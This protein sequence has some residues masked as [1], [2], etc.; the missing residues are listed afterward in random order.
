MSGEITITPGYTFTGE[1]DL[2]TTA[3]LN[4]LA[5]P[6]GRVTPGSITA[7]EIDAASVAGAL[8]NVAAAKNHFRDPLLIGPWKAT[9]GLSCAID[10]NIFNHADWWARPN[11]AGGPVV[12]VSRQTV[13]PT[14]TT[15]SRF[16][17]KVTGDAATTGQVSIGQSLP[18]AVT[19]T[20]RPD[21]VVSFWLYNGTG[22]D[23][24][25]SVALYGNSSIDDH[26]TAAVLDSQQ[27][28]ECGNGN[29][30]LVS[31]AFTT[32]ALTN[33]LNGG[34]VRVVIPSGFLD[35]GGKSV[36]I[37]Q[38]Q[39]ERASVAS[40]FIPP[41]HRRAPYIFSS[42]SNPAVTNDW[43]EGYRAGDVWINTTDNGVFVC[44]LADPT[45]AAVWVS[46][47]AV[48]PV[49]G[50]IHLQDRKTQNT[51]GGTATSGAFFTR[52]LNTELV[53]TGNHCTLSG[54]LITL[55]AGT[56]EILAT[57][58]G[59][60]VGSFQA[61]LINTTDGGMVQDINGNELYSDTACSAAA[62][63]VMVRATLMGRF[64][65]A[66]G[67]A[68][69]LSMRVQTNG[70]TTGNGIAANFG[71]EIYTQVWLTKLA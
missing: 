69:S 27:G 51:A 31:V 25:P 67:K 66:A 35:A 39:L 3:K 15:A 62:D 22:T 48:L 37:A 9:G 1:N 40:D 58:P 38:M 5:R 12:D 2:V 43:T 65:I 20:L 70:T 10:G 16:A 14:G 13:T 26:S 57:V 19:G 68:L 6:V 45:G 52:D 34:D 23:F 61:A 8:E 60:K 7:T 56:Y 18:A 55:A 17:L 4:Q 64:T 28:T 54:N 49:R 11:D 36:S 24:T 42:T 63:G 71:P 33:W 59:Y 50:V 30:T 21:I 46:T 32:T 44:R 53:D 47:V 41:E 29:W